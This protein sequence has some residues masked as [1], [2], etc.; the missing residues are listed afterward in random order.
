MRMLFVLLLFTFALPVLSAQEPMIIPPTDSQAFALDLYD[1]IRAEEGNLFF[2]PYSINTALLMTYIGARENTAQQMRDVLHIRADDPLLNQLVNDYTQLILANN[3]ADKTEYNPERIFTVSNNLWIQQDFALLPTYPQTL[4]EFYNAQIVPLNFRNDPQGSRQQINDTVA[5]QTR[6]RIQDLIPDG[7]INADT[8]LILTNA[9]YFKANWAKKF[10]DLGDKPFTLADSTVI[11]APAMRVLSD[12]RYLAGDGF[13]AVAVPYDGYQ[14]QMVIILP[15]DLTAYETAL[16]Q[17]GLPNVHDARL[18]PV[19]LTMPKFEFTRDFSLSDALITLGMT[20]AFDQNLA[21]FRNIADA[22]LFIQEVL[23]KAFIAVDEFGSEAA[24]A[25]AVIIGVT[26]AMP[27]PQAPIDIVVD[28]PF[29]FY[30][31]D[32]TTA[33]ILFMG[34]VMNPTE[35]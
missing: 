8:R 25:T 34:R 30:I 32:T 3:N 6:Q 33:E 2:S 16:P 31:Q 21:N 24:A 5:E 18:I 29:L 35:R 19:R 26:S 27:N 10:E 13:I 20:D 28:K 22:D 17:T 1:A 4:T 12:L 11:D 15:D 14:A 9:I 7:I 23:H